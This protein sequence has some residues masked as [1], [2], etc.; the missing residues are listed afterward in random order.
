MSA[1]FRLLLQLIYSVLSQRKGTVAVTN[2]L[3]FWISAPKGAHDSGRRL[4]QN[5]KH[6]DFFLGIESEFQK[7]AI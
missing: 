7:T 3:H 1:D 4:Q 5:Q 6:F 2:P